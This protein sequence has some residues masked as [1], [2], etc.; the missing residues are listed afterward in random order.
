MGL[1]IFFNYSN[2]ES[3]ENRKIF[4]SGIRM[5]ELSKKRSLSKELKISNIRSKYLEHKYFNE[6]EKS[7]N[8]KYDNYCLPLK[9]NEKKN[10]KD[11]NNNSISSFS[12][13]AFES[14]NGNILINKKEIEFNE[15]KDKENQNK[16]LFKGKK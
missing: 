10:I 11:S 14:K 12:N 1:D 5:K 4:F 6:F 9:R 13:S 7:P 2:L 16:E 3:I 15:Y 8:E